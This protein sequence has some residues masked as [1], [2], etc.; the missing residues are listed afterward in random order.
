MLQPLDQAKH[1]GGRGCLGHLPQPSEPTQTAFVLALSERIEA[2]ALLGRKPIGQPA[3]CLSPRTVAEVSAQPLQRHG[4]WDGDAALTARLHHHFGQ[5]GKPIVLDRW[6]EQ[7]AFQLGCGVL[8]E[9][10]QP[11]LLLALDDVTLPVPIRGE[12]FVDG[13]RKNVD[14]I[15]DERQQ[16]SRRPLTGTQRATRETQIT[17]HQ[18]I[19]DTVMIPTQ[20]RTAARSASE[21]V[22][23]RTN[24]RC[25][26]GGSNSSAI[27]TSLNRCRRVTLASLN[28]G[29]SRP[30]DP[31]QRVDQSAASD[32]KGPTD[33]C[34]AG[35]AIERRYHG[36]K[37]LRINGN[38]APSAPPAAASRGKASLH[39][40]LD[41]R[42]LELCK[43]TENVE[44]QFALWRG[45]VDLLSQ[46]SEC[47]AALLEPCYRVQEM[48]QRTAEPI[49]LPD[50]QAVAGTN[51]RECFGQAGAITAAAA[52]PV[53]E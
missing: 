27:W 16:S 50:H 15:S 21:S 10:A 43:R 38:G 28:L 20:R 35:S 29:S 33:R 40:F 18:C 17:E 49:Q 37:L 52:R 39:P 19:T 13:I 4:R 5:E 14:L 46:R 22:K 47:D 36:G 41:Q 34:L 24:S 9:R 31:R 7:R 30:A 42:P 51:K 25:S 26:V 45:R 1:A 11:K 32:P 6:D 53:V 12:I 44:Q 8:A 3:M 2:L 23:W 48:R